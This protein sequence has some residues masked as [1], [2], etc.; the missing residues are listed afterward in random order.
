MTD[1]NPERLLAIGDIHGCF[2]L[3]QKLLT[4]VAP[5]PEDQLVFLGDYIDRGPAS[6]QVIE[7]LLDLQRQFP[8]TV[9][10]R[11]NHEQMLLD[12]LAGDDHLMFL[13]NGGNATLESYQSTDNS[14]PVIPPDHLSFFNNLK[15]SYIHG[16]YIFVHAGLRPGVPISNQDEYDMLW[17]RGEFI[18]SDYDW[19]KTV[20]FGH[21]PQPEVLLRDNMVGLDTGAVYNNRLSC[22]DLLTRNIWQASAI[23]LPD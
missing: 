13:L 21:S 6:R 15:N 8:E 20:V 5:G 2:D 10:L 9:F 23:D 12:F 1:K 16:D 17:I 3:L 22:C 7:C 11:G 14:K 4:D 18:N 19:G